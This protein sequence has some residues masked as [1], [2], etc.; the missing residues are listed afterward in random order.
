MPGFVEN[1]AKEDDTNES[2]HLLREEAKVLRREARDADFRDNDEIYDAL[3]KWNQKVDGTLLAFLAND[4][5][6]P[7]A[8]R[9]EGTDAEIQDQVRQAILEGKYQPGPEHDEL[10]VIQEELLG[11]DRRIH[12]SLVA[13]VDEHAVDYFL[14]EGKNPV[15]T[16]LTVREPLGLID[17]TTNARAAPG[18]QRTY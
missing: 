12:K 3:Q 18:F 15:S 1:Y 6:F 8:F 4:F 2:Y 9:P 16:F 5:G 13:L 7:V 14:P 11:L 17:W 10:E